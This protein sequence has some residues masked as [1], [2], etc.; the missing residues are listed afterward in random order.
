MMPAAF[1]SRPT[2]RS[3]SASASS[4]IRTS[5]SCR[6]R[7]RR[8]SSVA[9]LAA[10][11]SSYRATPGCFALAPRPFPHLAILIPV[12]STSPLRRC[13]ITRWCTNTASNTFAQQLRQV[14]RKLASCCAQSPSIRSSRSLRAAKRC[15]Q[16]QRSLRP[17]PAL[18]WFSVPSISH[19][20]DNANGPT[21]RPARCI[22]VRVRTTHAMVIDSSK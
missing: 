6:S 17:N 13:P 3:A 18:A 10:S 8:S 5:I 20:F 21:R 19:A 1:S 9:I 14:L 22:S 2:L 12:D 7:L 4:T 16:S 11:F 15:H